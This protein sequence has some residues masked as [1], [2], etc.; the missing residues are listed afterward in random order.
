MGGGDG[1]AGIVSNCVAAAALAGLGGSNIFSRASAEN[2]SFWKGFLGNA[3]PWLSSPS[4]TRKVPA[5]GSDTAVLLSGWAMGEASRSTLPVAASRSRASSSEPE[6]EVGGESMPLAE[7]MYGFDGAREKSG[8]LAVDP[9]RD[10][11]SGRATPAPNE[12]N[13]PRLLCVDG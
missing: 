2:I 8:L 10:G 7:R 12:R 3:L 6:I 4:L 9:L 13:E 5:A 11:G 1:L